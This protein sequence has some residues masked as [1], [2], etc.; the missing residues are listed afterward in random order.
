MKTYYSVFISLIIICNSISGQFNFQNKTG[1]DLFEAGTNLIKAGNYKSADSLLTIALCTYKDENVY[2][3][4]A[5]AR[6]YE[7][8]TVESCADLSIASNK[9][10]DIEASRMFHKFCCKSVDTI[11]YDNKFILADRGRYRYYE[12]K[13]K[14]KY[15][16]K[17]SGTFHAKGLSR[18]VLSIDYG[19]DNSLVTLGTRTTDLI[20]SYIMSDSLKFFT[21]ATRRAY[22]FNENDYNDIKRRGELVLRAKYNQIKDDNNL[23]KLNVFY[24]ITISHTGKVLRIEYLGTDPIIELGSLEVDLKNDLNAIVSNY[25]KFIPATFKGKKVNFITFDYISF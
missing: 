24:E 7:M 20:G 23:E 9:Y 16:D 17:E 21:S 8:D 4:R 18:D 5:V 12:V 14:E 2:F 6:L 10:F 15:T 3:N 11:F 1:A 22:C 25:P 13:I 19:C